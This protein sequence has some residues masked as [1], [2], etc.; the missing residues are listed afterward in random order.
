MTSHLSTI[1]NDSYYLNSLTIK[2]C[3][4]RFMIQETEDMNA[5]S[6]MKLLTFDVTLAQFTGIFCCFVHCNQ[7]LAT[8]I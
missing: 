2:I 6:D 4:V 3:A 7:S 1:S 5:E 8:V